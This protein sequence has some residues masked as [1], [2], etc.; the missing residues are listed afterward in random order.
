[1]WAFTYCVASRCTA[2]P[3]VQFIDG[4]WVRVNDTG[5]PVQEDDPFGDE[6]EFP[7]SGDEADE[8][9]PNPNASLTEDIEEEEEDWDAETDDNASVTTGNSSLRGSPR[10][11]ISSVKGDKS[12]SKQRNGSTGPSGRECTCTRTPLSSFLV[13]H[14]RT[15]LLLL[16]VMYLFGC[17]AVCSCSFANPTTAVS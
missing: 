5:E 13:V 9:G 6:D 15:V 4:K 16:A 1:M 3:D 17:A 12:K 8:N 7:D 10:S 14:S 11:S 2:A